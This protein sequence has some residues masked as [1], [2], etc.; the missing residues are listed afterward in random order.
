[1]DKGN[2]IGVYGETADYSGS[3]FG[4]VTPFSCYC[5]TMFDCTPDKLTPELKQKAVNNWKKL[6]DQFKK[7][8][9]DMAN[10]RCGGMWYKETYNEFAL[11]KSPKTKLDVHFQNE[12]NQKPNN[13]Y[14]LDD[15][16]KKID[17][18]IL[19]TSK[20]TPFDMNRWS[21]LP[22]GYPPRF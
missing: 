11:K 20:A 8:Y 5:R 13:E 12:I 2:D 6:Q 15:L 22:K 16:I 7:Y 18:A 9:V 3:D 21:F 10:K 19:L 17:T 1:M 4:K 14:N